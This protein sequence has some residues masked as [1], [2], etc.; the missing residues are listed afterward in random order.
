MAAKKHLHPCG[1]SRDRHDSR[2]HAYELPR[3][4]RG[5]LP[6][7]V[8]LRRK[9]PPVYNQGH[10]NSCSANAI[11]AALW[12]DVKRR[13]G[14]SHGHGPSRLFIYYNE[15]VRE[16]VVSS[17]AEVSLRTG[18][19]TV[20]RNGVCAERH[21][22]YD[23]R[24]YRRKPS[25]FCYEAAEEHRAIR[26]ERLPQSLRHMHACLAEGYPFTVGLGLHH[27]YRSALVKR[28]GVLSLPDTGRDP[29]LG[30]HAVLIVGYY[31][32]SRH[33]IVRNSAGPK[34]GDNGYGYVPYRYLLDPD[35][36]WDLWTVRRLS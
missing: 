36:A 13:H 9:M 1:T 2:D 22:P 12:W 29:F 20:S 26:Y 14:R 24:R 27:T 34:W 30:G 33:F 15:R 21:W 7:E 35:L 6:R 28:T 4:L 10:L 18:Y 11:A 8:D 32:D 3:G 25:S 31:E 5:S 19:K 23:V 16:G 17:N